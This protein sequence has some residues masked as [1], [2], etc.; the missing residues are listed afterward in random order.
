VH[1][2]EGKHVKALR[3]YES[4]LAE[5]PHNQYALYGISKTLA[6]L[7]RRKEAREAYEKARRA[8]SN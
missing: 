1:G 6:N 3:L 2:D 4:V 7:G 8:S 5:D